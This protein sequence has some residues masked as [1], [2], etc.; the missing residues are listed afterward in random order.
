MFCLVNITVPDN[1]IAEKIAA[2]LIDKRLAACV[3]CIDNVRSTYRWQGKIES[4]DEKLLV[5]KTRKE[6]FTDLCELVKEIHPYEVP[7]IIAIPIVDIDES[8]T[9]WMQESLDV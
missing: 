5:V 3:N 9:Q 4:E 7:E 1:E 8:Y 6:F 2:K